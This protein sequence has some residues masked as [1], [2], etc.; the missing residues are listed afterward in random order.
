MRAGGAIIFIGHVQLAEQI[1]ILQV[2]LARG[3]A[4]RDA[5][6][7]ARAGERAVAGLQARQIAVDKHIFKGAGVSVDSRR[8]KQQDGPQG[9]QGNPTQARGG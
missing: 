3:A 8:Q 7:Q 1:Q 2:V 5:L 4:R 6:H 9:Q